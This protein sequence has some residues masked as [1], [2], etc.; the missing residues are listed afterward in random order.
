[1]YRR[2]KIDP[3]NPGYIHLNARVCDTVWLSQLTSERLKRSAHNGFV[4]RRY[5]P[6]RGGVA[7]EALD[8][9]VL[10]TA[11]LEVLTK[12]KSFTFERMAD[13]I[14]RYLNPRTPAVRSQPPGYIPWMQR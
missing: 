7:N 2:L 14:E 4:T 11:A 5:V 13:E 12:R 1:M 3:G 8:C 10:A 6:V 9:F